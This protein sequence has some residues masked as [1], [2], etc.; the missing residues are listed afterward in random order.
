[1]VKSLTK[2]ETEREEK[3]GSVESELEL[4][5][6]QLKKELDQRKLY[7]QEITAYKLVEEERN[8]LRKKN[9]ELTVELAKTNERLERTISELGLLDSKVRDLE[10]TLGERTKERDSLNAKSNSL[11][12][13][14]E[15]LTK[16]QDRLTREN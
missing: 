1:M 8:Q 5:K 12:K 4:S 15:A 14:V 9:N 11:K 3:L 7:E 13:E 10:G 2:R 6:M 16:E